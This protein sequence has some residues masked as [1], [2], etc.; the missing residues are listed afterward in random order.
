MTRLRTRFA[1]IIAVLALAGTACTTLGRGGIEV[2]AVFDDT[3]DLVIDAHVRAG[4]VPIGRI[5]E[6]SLTDDMRALVTMQIEDDT[7][8]PAD[9]EALLL[10]T[11][12]LGERFVELR[13][14]GDSGTLADGTFIENTRVVRDIED[15]TATGSDLLGL[16]AADRLA[17]A[18]ET[19]AIA[20]GGRGG[21]LGTFIDE[22]ETFVGEYDESKDDLVRLIDNMDELLEGLA[23]QADVNADALAVL[24]DASETLGEEDDR[25]LDALDDLR[26]LAIVGE[27]VMATNASEIDAGV[28]RLRRILDQITRIDGAFQDLLTWLPRHNL[29]VPNAVV[30]DEAQVWLDFVVCGMSDDPNNPAERCDPYPEEDQGKGN[31]PPAYVDEDDAC[32]DDHD[33]CDHRTAK[34][35]EG[36]L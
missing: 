3:I 32:N 21:V 36:T 23:S 24:A 27:R 28:R 16:V 19:G 12:L 30:G 1:G 2:Q 29:H 26:R 18:V 35:Q 31:E 34:M 4:D 33:E 5:A 11:S 20:F 10:Q 15:L 14:V 6:I 22:I 25:L 17:A 13:A 9:V 7:G 8:L